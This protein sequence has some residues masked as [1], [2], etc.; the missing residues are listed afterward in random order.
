LEVGNFAANDWGLF[1]MHGNVREWVLDH[2]ADRLPGGHLTSP[3]RRS[4]LNPPRVVRGGSWA[5]LAHRSRSAARDK[6]SPESRDSAQGFRIVLAP[7]R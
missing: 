6:L 5:E 3:L 7:E 4:S 1:D 2:F